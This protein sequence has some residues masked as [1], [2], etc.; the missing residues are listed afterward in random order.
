MSYSNMRTSLLNS[1]CYFVIATKKMKARKKERKREK[2]ERERKQSH[3]AVPKYKNKALWDLLF[4]TLRKII[5]IHLSPILWLSG[6][7]Y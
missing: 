7:I 1:F 3:N 2:R 5:I 4:S 6:P